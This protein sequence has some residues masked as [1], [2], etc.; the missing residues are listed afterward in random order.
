MW[1]WQAIFLS[2]FH[3][4]NVLYSDS[5][6]QFYVGCQRVDSGENQKSQPEGQLE[7]APKG[8]Q[9]GY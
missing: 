1:T 2:F 9:A 8:F 5:Y 4:S 7:T 6:D 3:A